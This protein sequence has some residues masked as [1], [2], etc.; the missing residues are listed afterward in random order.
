MRVARLAIAVCAALIPLSP[1]LAQTSPPEGARSATTLDAIV[2]KGEKTE[3][4]LQDTTTSVAVTTEMRME[5]ENLT[6]L[7]QVFD[8]T[9][10]LSRTYGDAG[11]TIR[12]INRYTDQTQGL[13]HGVL[14]APRVAGIGFEAHW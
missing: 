14:G 13:T 6:S 12:G 7:Y 8:R 9:A 3:R 5:Q 2:V 4:D 10:N 1:A 11:F